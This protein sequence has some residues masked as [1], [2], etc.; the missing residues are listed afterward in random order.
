MTLDLH[1]AVLAL[2]GENQRLEREADAN[3][4]YAERYRWLRSAPAMFHP[5]FSAHDS[6]HWKT[7]EMIDAAIDAAREGK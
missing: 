7:P 2:T 5:A 3:R 1:E 6:Q 4:Q